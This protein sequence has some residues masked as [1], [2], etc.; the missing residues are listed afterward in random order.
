MKQIKQIIDSL[1]TAFDKNFTSR[2]E[3]DKALIE[4]KKLELETLE[5]D[6][7]YRTKILELNNQYNNQ[8]QETWLQKNWRPILFTGL[9]III[10]FNYLIAPLF[11]MKTLPL[12]ENIWTLI[13]FGVGGY[14]LFLGADK[15]AK[16][17]KSK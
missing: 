2:E 3:K 12:D 4:L 10:F 7:N 9:T 8:N 16:T 11:S 15:V 1:G 6:A 13:Q 17:I 14:T 5:Q